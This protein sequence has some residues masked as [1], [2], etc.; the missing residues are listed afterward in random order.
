MLLAETD[1][2]EGVLIDPVVSEHRRDFVLDNRSPAF[3]GDALL[4]HGCGRCDVQLGDARILYRAITTRIVQRPET[5]LLH[6]MVLLCHFGNR[7][8]LATHLLQKAGLERVANLRGGLRA[9]EPRG[10][11]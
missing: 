1:S 7:S 3:T 5:C 6:P 8:A 11:L 2:E 9:W 10:W 4:I